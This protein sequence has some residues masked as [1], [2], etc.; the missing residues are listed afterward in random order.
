MLQLQ[1]RRDRLAEV[2]VDFDAREAAL[3]AALNGAR[4]EAPD[5]IVVTP[6]TS[7]ELTLAGDPASRREALV[8]HP[9]LAAHRARADAA[10]SGAAQALIEARP[11]PTV[12]LGYRVRAP[13]ITGDAGTNFVTAGV[14]VPLP[15]ASARRFEAA[16]LAQTEQARASEAAA[17]GVHRR[18]SA[19]LEGA[20]ARYARAMRRA[21][22]HRDALLPAARTALDS[23]L[24]AY[25]VDRATFADLIRTEIALL[26]VERELLLAATDAARAHAEITTLLEAP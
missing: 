5:A 8:Q 26:E 2:L 4:A 24:S 3:L 12:W 1:L 23:T 7:P 22:V 19:A 6:S 21:E 20:E 17:E 16:A 15:F 18:L 14:S 13:T 11:E 9:R 10:R 25:Q